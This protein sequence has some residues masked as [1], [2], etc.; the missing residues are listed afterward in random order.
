MPNVFLLDGTSA[1]RAAGGLRIGVTTHVAAG[2]SIYP[3][4]YQNYTFTEH[5]R[6]SRSLR[7]PATWIASPKRSGLRGTSAPIVL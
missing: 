4:I 2:C 5:D 1:I 7:D 6:C 3:T